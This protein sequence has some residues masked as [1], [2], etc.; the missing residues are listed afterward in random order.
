MLFLVCAI[1]FASTSTLATTQANL[2]PIFDDPLLWDDLVVRGKV[3]GVSA[4]T[5]QA[6]DWYSI[7][8]IRYSGTDPVRFVR[9][10]IADPQYL[11]GTTSK[12]ELLV[13]LNYDY[14]DLGG[15][16]DRRLHVG[17][18]VVAT[19]HF[20][21]DKGIWIATTLLIRDG[22]KWG[23]LFGRDSIP[24]SMSDDDITK[25]V[26][27]VGV[28]TMT[29]ES[30]LVIQARVVAAELVGPNGRES[31]RFVVEPWRVL[32]GTAEGR[33][34]I[35]ADYGPGTDWRRMIYA[36]ELAGNYYIF[37]RRDGDIFVP[38]AGRRSVFRLSVG[39]Q[40]IE[41][42]EAPSSYSAQ[43]LEDAVRE[44]VNST[45]R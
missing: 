12:S 4:E 28:P 31:Y 13:A 25:R 45:G 33:V 42:L 24:E 14:K 41:N 2:P 19:A 44:S 39:E 26:E 15:E 10:R 27:M 18:E 20:R 22:K 35:N 30:D 37:L 38:T 5:W 34:T 3:A 6:D 1:L 23:R 9:V 32:K 8:G 40:L 7:S 43:T 16:I 36:L 21:A 29:A 17:V 11:R